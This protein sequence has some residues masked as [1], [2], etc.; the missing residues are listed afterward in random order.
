[1]LKIEIIDE[2]ITEAHLGQPII[3][4]NAFDQQIGLITAPP[5]KEGNVE[6]TFRLDSHGLLMMKKSLNLIKIIK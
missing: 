6:V 4:V 5:D 3:N 1:M 2:E